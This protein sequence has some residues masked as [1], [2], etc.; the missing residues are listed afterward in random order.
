MTHIKLKDVIKA[1]IA[2]KMTIDEYYVDIGQLITS[3][4]FNFNHGSDEDYRNRAVNL[5]MNLKADFQSNSNIIYDLM[6]R[7]VKIKC[8]YC[9]A[10]MDVRGGGGNSQ[11][12]TLNYVCPEHAQISL[13]LP[14]DGFA[15]VFKHGVRKDKGVN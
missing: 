15:I 14:S 1:G 3:D 7:F 13:S 10:W 12:H 8:P 5:L 11:M 9:D 2:N 4:E 6:K